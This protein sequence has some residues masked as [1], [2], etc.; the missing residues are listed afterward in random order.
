MCCRVWACVQAIS[1]Y[2]LQWIGFSHEFIPKFICP[3]LFKG[4]ISVNGEKAP[5]LA[6]KRMNNE[7]WY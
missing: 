5:C 1:F 4:M 7:L 3:S 2:S 6:R